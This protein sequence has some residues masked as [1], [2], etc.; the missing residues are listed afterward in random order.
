MMSSYR[1]RA[2]FCVF[3]QS[4]RSGSTSGAVGCGPPVVSGVSPSVGAQAR[5]FTLKWSNHAKNSSLS[6][7]YCSGS[8]LG[9]AWRL[10]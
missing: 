7:L 1:W 6:R 10:Q 4:E 5:M 2:Q 8:M 9:S 3:A